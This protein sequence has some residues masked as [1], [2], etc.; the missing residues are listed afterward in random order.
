M[1]GATGSCVTPGTQERAR[2]DKQQN[3]IPAVYTRL[4][5]P[6]FLGMMLT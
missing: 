6:T 4:H 1:P 3:V 2:K 5:S